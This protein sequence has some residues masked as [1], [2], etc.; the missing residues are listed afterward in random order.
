MAKQSGLGDNLYVDGVDISGDVGSLE[1]IAGPQKLIEVTAINKSAHERI[2]GQRDGK[3]AFTAYFNATGAHP[4]LSTLPTAD[5]VLSYV[6]GAALG[7]PCASM[8]AKQIDYPVTRSQAGDLT[9]KVEA[10]ANGF[11]L[12]WGVQLTSGVR[13][14]GAATNGASVNH[15]A[16]TAFGLQAYLHVMAFTGTDVTVKIQDSA[17]NVTFA[18]V[19][20]AAFTQITAAPGAQRLVISNAATVRQYVRAV[21]VTTG[22][23]SSLQFFVQ[24]TINAIAGQVF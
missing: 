12:E 18:D 9:M 11:G 17:D 10:D 6:R 22:G 21:T 4:A 24:A 15:L 1:S 14:D 13:T 8:V 19:A 16:S 5:R 20:G 3:I 7:N 23:F 2:G